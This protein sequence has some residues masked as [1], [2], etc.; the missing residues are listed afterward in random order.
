[1]AAAAVLRARPALN[2]HTVAKCQQAVEKALHTI[3][4]L[5]VE[6]S[7]EP[8]AVDLY[9]HKP[10][11]FIVAIQRAPAQ[12]GDLR[13]CAQVLLDKH[14][15]ALAGR[16]D[17]AIWQLCALAP[18]KP[19]P[20]DRHQRNTE[21]PYQHEDLSWTIPSALHEFETAETDRWFEVAKD[22]VRAAANLCAAAERQPMATL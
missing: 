15:H 5:F 1:M 8:Q 10:I 4:M 17:N 20:G 18:R 16:D 13:S 12:T 7:L 21:Y 22:V 3:E 2:C 9:Q 19:R 11:R 6:K 14:L